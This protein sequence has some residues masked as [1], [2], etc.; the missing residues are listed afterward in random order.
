MVAVA[1]LP[2]LV[3][4]FGGFNFFK[5]ETARRPFSPETRGSVFSVIALYSVL[6][7]QNRAYEIIE[8]LTTAGAV[9]RQGSPR[10]PV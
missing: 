8:F 6:I 7:K 5:Q 4:P 3:T 2:N 10:C 1:Y 9:N